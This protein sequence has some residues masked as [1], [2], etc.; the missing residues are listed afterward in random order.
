MKCMSELS[1]TADKKSRRRRRLTTST[2]KE[3]VKRGGNCKACKSG[4]KND[5][6]RVLNVV[7]ELASFAA[8]LTHGWDSR[9]KSTCKRHTRIQHLEMGS[10]MKYLKPPKS[11]WLKGA[12]VK[13]W[14]PSQNTWAHDRQTLDKREQ[15]LKGISFITSSFVNTTSW[16]NCKIHVWN[17]SGKVGQVLS[18]T[19]DVSSISSVLAKIEK[20]EYLPM[21]VNG[22]CA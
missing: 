14:T 3:D 15:A 16:N 12:V 1:T 7:Q 19:C 9:L 13:K 22:I 21:N 11:P 6:K 4:N 8:N 17:F 10:S 18:I 5:N 20:Q 2:W